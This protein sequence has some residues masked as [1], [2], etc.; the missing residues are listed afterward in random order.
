MKTI[1]KAESTVLFQGD[2][3]TD[4]GRDG[5]LLMDMFPEGGGALGKGYAYRAA[6]IYEWLFP[7]HP[8]KIYKQRRFRRQMPEPAGKIPEGYSGST[9]GLSVHHDRNQ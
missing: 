8:G 5:G 7:N 3:I 4:W 9:S 1:F 2:S 6:K